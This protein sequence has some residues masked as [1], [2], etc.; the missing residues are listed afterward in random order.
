MIGVSLVK[1]D[2]LKCWTRK[3]M[4]ETIWSSCLQLCE[5][6]VLTS[7]L[8]IFIIFSSFPPASSALQRHLLRI[9]TGLFAIKNWIPFLDQRLKKTTFLIKT[10][11][12]DQECGS[13][14]PGCF[15]STPV[16]CEYTWKDHLSACT[17]ATHRRVGMKFL[18]PNLGLT[19][20]VLMGMNQ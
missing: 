14:S 5:T 13:Q 8:H 12:G 6:V 15:S 19:Q 16:P 9:G 4:L 17:A 10:L 7:L 1:Q 2:F 20:T 18:H 3:W 11:N